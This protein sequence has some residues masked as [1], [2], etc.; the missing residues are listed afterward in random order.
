MLILV[1]FAAFVDVSPE[2][3]MPKSPF[4]NFEDVTST[5]PSKDA[6]PPKEVSVCSWNVLVVV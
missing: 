2:E 1:L 3:S 6:Q 5:S 4:D